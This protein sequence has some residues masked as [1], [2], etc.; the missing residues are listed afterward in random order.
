MATYVSLLNW[1]DQGMRNVKD[2][3]KRAA[4]ARKAFEAAGGKIVD[5]YYT[6][7][8]H[9]VVVISEAPDDAT[10]YRVLLQV[11]MQGNVRTTTMK[12]MDEKEMAEILKGVS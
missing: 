11:G 4:A 6:L 8:Q 7:G 9:D 12:A 2:S 5:L 3:L 1:T 10:V